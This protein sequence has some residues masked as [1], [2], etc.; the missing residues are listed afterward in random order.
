MREEAVMQ[1]QLNGADYHP[2]LVPTN[3]HGEMESSTLSLVE[4]VSQ[5][6]LELPTWL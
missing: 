3:P 4:T 6:Q 5:L 2:G 1:I